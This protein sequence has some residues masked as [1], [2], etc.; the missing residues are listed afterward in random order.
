VFDG[1]PDE[2]LDVYFRPCSLLV[3]SSDLA[4]MGATP[5]RGGINSMT[6]RRATDNAV[7]QRTLSLTVTCANCW[8]V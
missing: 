6:G 1:D 3:T 8:P 7:V 4:R 2:V 5:A